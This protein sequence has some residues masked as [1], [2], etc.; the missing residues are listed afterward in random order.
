M[1]S[2]GRGIL[3]MHSFVDAIRY[4]LGG[5][6]LTMT[7]NRL[8]GEEKRREQRTAVHL[9]FRVTPLKADGTPDW[10]AA[11]EAVS[12]DFSRHGVALIQ[13]GLARG[14]RVLIAVTREGETIYVPAEV[15]HCRTLAPGCVEVGCEFQIAP[16]EPP[17]A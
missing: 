1:L 2:S 14:Q 13:E 11:Y 3:M 12:R 5:R 10:P 8:S 16:S 17:P 7:L 15:R 6:Q 4:D 9:P